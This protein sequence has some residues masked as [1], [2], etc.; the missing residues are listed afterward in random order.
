MMCPWAEDAAA[1]AEGA[2]TRSS[3]QE[4]LCASA[5]FRKKRKDYLNL[6]R[7]CGLKLGGWGF[8]LIIT[9]FKSYKYLVTLLYF[10]EAFK[11]RH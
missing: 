4:P 5:L 10:W 8:K 1:L 6:N 2:G 11:N 3:E 7:G 9:G